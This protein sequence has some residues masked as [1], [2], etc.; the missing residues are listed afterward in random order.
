MINAENYKQVLLD[1]AC[2]KY[3]ERFQELHDNFYDEFP[4]KVSGNI[5]GELYLNHFVS[6][7][8]YE[9]AI[10][11]TGKTIV[12]EYV[13]EHSDMDEELKQDLL[14]TMN[15]VSSRFVITFRK[16]LNL[17]LKDMD[18]KK[19]YNVVL[20]ID[21]PQLTTNSLV[22][23]RIHPFGG[24]FR[25]LG[26]LMVQ[27]SSPFIWDV[28][29]LMEQYKD[30]SIT[31]AEQMVMSPKSRL[32]AVLNKY[33]FQWVDGICNNLGLSSKGK[34]NIKVK[35]IAAKVKSDL[36]SIV[37]S[38][39]KKSR[40]ALKVVLDNDG[41]VKYNK[42]KDFDDEITFWWNEN[43]PT[44][45]IGVLRLNALLA[46]GRIPMAGRMYRSALIPSDIRSELQNLL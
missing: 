18:S 29:V 24:A 41:F 33:P 15:V 31:D 10:P 30:N 5:P 26:L 46:V 40:N 35:N 23:G 34:K 2:E 20:D 7:L 36:A 3:G 38:L 6:W 28:D 45:T 39:P 37:D 19:V 14:Q 12:E 9:K 42:L 22:T 21:N 43:P 44:S 1:Y 16:G 25:F 8:V 27:P 11:D 32:T 4:Y 13:D 17:K